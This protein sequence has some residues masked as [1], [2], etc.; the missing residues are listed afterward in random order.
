MSAKQTVRRKRLISVRQQR[1]APTEGP[2]SVHTTGD[3]RDT[4]QLSEVNAP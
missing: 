3:E 4:N 1:R 2:A